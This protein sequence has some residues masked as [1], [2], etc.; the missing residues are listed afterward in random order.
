MS[1]SAPT[2]ATTK[3]HL[4]NIFAKAGVKRHAELMRLVSQV[5]PR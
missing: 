4:I 3:T 5:L 2:L 1:P